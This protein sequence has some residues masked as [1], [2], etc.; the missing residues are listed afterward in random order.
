MRPPKRSVVSSATQS[1]LGASPTP[2]SAAP[3][4]TPAEAQAKSRASSGRL[5]GGS[6]WLCPLVLVEDSQLTYFSFLSIP[7]NA[8]AKISHFCF[9]NFF[10]PLRSKNSTLQRFLDFCF[11]FFC[12]PMPERILF[13]FVGDAYFNFLRF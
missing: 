2:L 5:R 10:S 13:S 8:S 12:H 1:P 7:A 11:M 9:T 4:W 6:P 3:G